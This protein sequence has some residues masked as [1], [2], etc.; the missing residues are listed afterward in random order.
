[1]KAHG[2][3]IRHSHQVAT[4]RR[5]ISRYTVN[6][7]VHPHRRRIG[8]GKKEESSAPPPTHATVGMDLENMLSER[9][10]AEK[11]T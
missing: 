3:T 10:Q 7:L 11:V 6:T 1:M 5:A 8:G 9:S 2:I 4:T